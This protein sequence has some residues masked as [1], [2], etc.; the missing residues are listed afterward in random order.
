MATAQ[1]EK[2]EQ[3]YFAER[4]KEQNQQE[5]QTMADEKKTNEKKEVKK[6]PAKTFPGTADVDPIC[7]GSL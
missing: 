7:G 6:E 3:A 4:V 2:T 5:K 1:E